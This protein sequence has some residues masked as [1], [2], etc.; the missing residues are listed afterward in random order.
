MTTAS[1]KRRLERLEAGGESAP[2]YVWVNDWDNLPTVPD[3]MR[4]IYI[5]WQRNDGQAI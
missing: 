3:G 1:L 5:G 4:A 2:R